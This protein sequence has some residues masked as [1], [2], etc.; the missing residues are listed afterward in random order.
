MEKDNIVACVVSTVLVFVL[1][2]CARVVYGHLE[3]KSAGAHLRLLKLEVGVRNC[4]I[5]D[6]ARPRN[7]DV[8]YLSSTL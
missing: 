5:E 8:V 2:I 1:Y 7:K 3:L 4:T 6:L